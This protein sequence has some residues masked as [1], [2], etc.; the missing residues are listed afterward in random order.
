MPVYSYNIPLLLVSH[1]QAYHG[2]PVPIH[3]HFTGGGIGR[4]AVQQV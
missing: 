4:D 3:R 1:A 2:H